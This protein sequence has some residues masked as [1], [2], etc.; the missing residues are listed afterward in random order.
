MSLKYEKAFINS[1][2]EDFSMILYF[3]SDVWV[4]HVEF[5]RFQVLGSAIVLGVNFYIS[6]SK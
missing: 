4:F 3:V 1:I 2:I 5:N 6:F